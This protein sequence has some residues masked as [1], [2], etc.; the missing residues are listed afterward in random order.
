MKKKSFTTTI[1]IGLQEKF[2]TSCQSNSHKMN[3]VLEVFMQSYI[4]GDF[5]IKS[6]LT[7]IKK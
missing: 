4:S 1:D 6:E 7:L 3:D 2:K 5:I